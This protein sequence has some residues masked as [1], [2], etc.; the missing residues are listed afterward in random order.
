MCQNNVTAVLANYGGEVFE[1]FSNIA[2][3]GDRRKSFIQTQSLSLIGS[4]NDDESMRSLA[5]ARAKSVFPSK[6]VNGFGEFVDLDASDCNL[7][8]EPMVTQ[9]RDA[10]PS[11]DPLTVSKH[12]LGGSLQSLLNS[13]SKLC[14]NEYGEKMKQSAV[15]CPPEWNALTKDARKELTN[16]LSWD[17]LGKWEFNI[18]DVAKASSRKLSKSSFC[19]EEVGGNCPLLLVGWAILCAPMAQEAMEGSLGGDRSSSISNAT[20]EKKERVRSFPCYFDLNITPEKVCNFL[21]EIEKRYNHNIPYHNNVHAADVTQTLHCLLQFVGEE[22]ICQIWDPIEIFAILLAATF[23]DVG[24]DGMNNLYQKHTRSNLA[25][26]Y[27][28]ISIL[29][30]MHSAVG[31]SLLMGDEKEDEWDIFADWDSRQ[32]DKARTVM[33]NAVLGTDMSNHFESV[34]KITAMMEK[35]QLDAEAAQPGATERGTVRSSNTSN[36]TKQRCDPSGGEADGAILSILVRELDSSANNETN[37]DLK[38]EC[39]EFARFLLKLLMH[40]ADISNPTK[41]NELA[42]HWAEKALSEFFNQGK[43]IGHVYLTYIL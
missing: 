28:D 16:L 7:L 30:N 19:D 2:P 14:L 27:N 23:H 43:S 25:I 37:E 5:L 18:L 40:A 33:M 20:K 36:G 29:E 22:L 35:I 4:T 1:C 12:S 11:F 39:K 17:N 34:G 26:R 31:H 24:H 9:R 10:A 3:H 6:G 42:V 21:R 8:G 32:I 13:S 15:Y 41:V 38:M